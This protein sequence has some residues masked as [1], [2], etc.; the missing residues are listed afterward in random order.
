MGLCFVTQVEAGLVA[1]ESS[2]D[3][4]NVVVKD[5]K[6]VLPVSQFVP[7]D[8]SPA[9]IPIPEE[10]CA[11]AGVN[12]LKRGTEPLPC[13]AAANGTR[14]SGAWIEKLEGVVVEL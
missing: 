4:L 9:S 5:W 12:R 7:I 1:Q 11:A 10:I 13:G 6:N 14:T 3:T 8:G 2:N